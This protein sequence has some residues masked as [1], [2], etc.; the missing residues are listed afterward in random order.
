MKGTAHAKSP[1]WEIHISM[2][3]CKTAVIPVREQWSYCS[4]ALSHRYVIPPMVLFTVMVVCEL[5]AFLLT[6]FF[7]NI[8]AGVSGYGFL[9][10]VSG[11]EH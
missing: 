2:G 6:I 11:G 1:F 7:N 5:Y 4:F 10:P 8:S 3:L 9:V